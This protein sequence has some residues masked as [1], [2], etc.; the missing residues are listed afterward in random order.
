MSRFHTPPRPDLVRRDPFALRLVALTATA[1][2]LLLEFSDIGER[3]PSGITGTLI[4]WSSTSDPLGGKS[5]MRIS[6]TPEP[7]VWL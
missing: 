7:T 1:V 5:L 4:C 6:V 2:A 3:I